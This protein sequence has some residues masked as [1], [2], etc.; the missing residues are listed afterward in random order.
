M[1]VQITAGKFKGKKLRIP[2]FATD[3]RPTKQMVREAICSALQMDTVGADILEL[4]AGSGVFSFEM[5]S[6]GANHATMVEVSAERVALIRQ[7]VQELSLTTNTTILTSEVEQAIVGLSSKFDIV[8][9]DPPYKQDGLTSLIPKICTLLSPF[10]VLVFECATDDTFAL[11]LAVP[12][13]FEC[14][15]KKY[16]QTS[17][18]YFRKKE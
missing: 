15:S 17:I 13:G 12:K 9:F 16:G 3:F 6:R 14:R 8:F 2:E 4:C 5:L 11:E 1:D 18:R 7:I 10:G